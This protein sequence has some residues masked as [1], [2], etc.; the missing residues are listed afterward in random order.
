MIFKYK[1]IDSTGQSKEGTI[2]A[3]SIEVAISSLQKRELVLSNI[4]PV[5]DKSFLERNI[6]FFDKEYMLMFDYYKDTSYI[7]YPNL[8]V[9][10]ITDSSLNHKREILSDLELQY[11]KKCFISFNFKSI[12]GYK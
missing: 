6:S 1:A 9:S 7:C 2:E 11:Y 5:D 4:V 3:V 12:L 10:N 8:C